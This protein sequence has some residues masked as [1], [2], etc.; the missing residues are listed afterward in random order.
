VKTALSW[1][2]GKD[3]AWSLHV[4]REQ[5][6]EVS[7]LLTTVNEAFARV[8]MHAVRKEL[9][10]A[11]AEDVGIP[12][13]AIDLPWP[14]SNEVYENR[15]SAATQ[16]LISEDYTQIAFGDLFLR[17]IRSYREKQ[18]ESSQ[19]QPIFP[20]WNIPTDLLANQMLD[21]GLQACITTVDPRKL[22]A[23]FAGRTWDR[24]LIA[25]FPASIDPCGENGEF[26][27]FVYD[28]PVFSHP[29]DIKVG[30]IVERDG[31]IFADIV[32]QSQ[33]YENKLV[34]SFNR[35][36]TEPAEIK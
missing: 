7:C 31:F 23:S 5:G 11:Q 10:E 21:S 28:G 12:L 1:S 30:E 15:M 24:D 8:A 35:S 26:H 22:P 29:I 2:S 34:N 25:E 36:V 18:L 20:L 14:C 19:L 27:T 13:L 17:D 3:S 9:L 33:R 32:P 16:R 4:L 6:I